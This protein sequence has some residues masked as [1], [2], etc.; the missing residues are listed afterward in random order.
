MSYFIIYKITNNIDGKIYVGAHQTNNINDLYMGSGKYIKNAIKKH[1]I[2][3]FT[4]EILHLCNN[5]VDMYTKE[6]EI[7]NETFIR[8][9]D[10]YNIKLGGSGFKKEEQAN[11]NLLAVQKLKFLRETNPEW[12]N[13]DKQR[14]SVGQQLS[15]KRGRTKN[16]VP[17][18]PGK[19][20]HSVETKQQMSNNRKGV[21]TGTNNS[22]YGTRWIT[23]PT[24][25]E[26][27][28]IKSQDLSTYLSTGWIL[29]RI[30]Y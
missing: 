29:G 26:N 21:W 3:N 6:S 23:N 10:T 28:K 16:C 11:A 25:K 9:D 19:F 22:Q 13:K 5:A 30:T 7:V 15:Y 17:H 14:R 2:E 18:V 20:T 8:R 27:K 4:K 12:V 1:G 24:T